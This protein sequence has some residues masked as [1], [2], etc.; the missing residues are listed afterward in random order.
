MPF[1][2]PAPA[3][4]PLWRPT[5][6]HLRID[7]VPRRSTPAPG[8]TPPRGS[9]WIPPPSSGQ[10]LD[11]FDWKERVGEGARVVGHE[12]DLSG[13]QEL[14]HLPGTDLA[15][16]PH[17]GNGRE[18]TLDSI[19]AGP[20]TT[21]SQSSRRAATAASKAASK[22]KS[23]DPAYAAVRGEAARSA[24]ALATHPRPPLLPEASARADVASPAAPGS[25]PTRRER[26][27]SG[28]GSAT[29]RP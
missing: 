15:R 16:Q 6:L 1:A 26:H 12:A 20:A 18:S 21:N 27:P 24:A 13:R 22:R 23:T 17:V 5:G 19:R 14:R 9:A 8:A 3:P 29:P 10:I 28:P 11:R 25:A 2:P 7:P 4:S